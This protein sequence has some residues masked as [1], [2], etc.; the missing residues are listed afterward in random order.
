VSD[1][2]APGFFRY[3]H[4]AEPIGATRWWIATAG[5]ALLLSD[6]PASVRPFIELQHFTVREVRGGV[7]PRTLFGDDSFW[8]VTLG[9]R[10]FL[11]GEA[12]RMGSYGVLDPMAGMPAMPGM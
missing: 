1:T 8:G 3:E 11:G 12:M 2:D 9:A 10:I 7:D 6:L 4:D 5:Y